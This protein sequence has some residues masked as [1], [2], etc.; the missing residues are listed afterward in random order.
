MQ[1]VILIGVNTPNKVFYT[2]KDACD[3]L[4][5]T[6]TAFNIAQGKANYP[7]R[8]SNG[9]MYFVDMLVEEK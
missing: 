1:S 3:F 9:C 4:G 5:C 2:I 7:I 8:A 6:R